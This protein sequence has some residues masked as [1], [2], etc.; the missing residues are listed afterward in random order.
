MMTDPALPFVRRPDAA[1]RVLIVDD[2]TLVRLFYREA[3]QAAGFEVEEAINGIEAMEKVLS[4]RFDLLVVDVNMP[5]MD[6]LALLRALRAQAEVAS[7]PVL[8]TSSE[9][10]EHD[11][12]AARAAG[13]N[14]YL[15]KPISQE[16]LVLYSAVLTGAPA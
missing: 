11:V 14:Y 3:L 8:V 16:D 5:K 6:G 9:A 1:R 4:Q 13:A 7:V 15:V 2:A 10:A 12:A